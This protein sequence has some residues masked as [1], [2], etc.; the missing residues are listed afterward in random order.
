MNEGLFKRAV[1]GLERASDDSR[2]AA[3]AMERSSVELARATSALRAV[4]RAWLLGLPRGSGVASVPISLWE[5][6]DIRRVAELTE[7]SIGVR[8][9]SGSRLEVAAI[10]L[11]VLARLIDCGL[12]A[13]FNEVDLEVDAADDAGKEA[14]RAVLSWLE[15]YRAVKPAEEPAPEPEPEPES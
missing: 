13:P 3:A 15:R 4:G 1:R 10:E 7:D 11:A 6:I 14:D 2:A 8:I 12:S 9:R 5:A